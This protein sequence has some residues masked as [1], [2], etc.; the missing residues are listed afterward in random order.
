MYDLSCML[1]ELRP[2]EV[3]D[4]LLG[5]YGLKYN[6]A[7]TCGLLLY[8]CSYKLD[9]SATVDILASIFW[10][11]TPSVEVKHFWVDLDGM[12]Y[13]YAYPQCRSSAYFDGVYVIL[14]LRA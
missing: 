11:F 10:V 14:I 7:T 9:G 5:L 4:G 13:C 6:S 12:A 1:V 3:L 2:F 8:L